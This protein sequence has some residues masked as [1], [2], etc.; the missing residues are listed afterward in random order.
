MRILANED[1][2]GCL[3]RALRGAGHDVAWIWED[4]RG[5]T[6]TAVLARAQQEGRI[7]AT[8]DR[9]FA[10]LAFGAALPADCGVI[11]LRITGTP[12]R[13]VDTCLRAVASREDWKGQ[14]ASVMNDRIRVRPLPRTRR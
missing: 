5:S 3:V 9:D 10:A 13:Q 2:S 11:L 4:A 7:V 12:E 14:F 1:F 8:F 6:D